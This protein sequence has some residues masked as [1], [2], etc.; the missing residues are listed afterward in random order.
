MMTE[1]ELQQAY[2]NE[3][4]QLGHKE[5][6]AHTLAGR[7]KGLEAEVVSHKLK[8]DDLTRQKEELLK[9]KPAVSEAP[10]VDAEVVSEVKKDA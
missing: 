8:L 3:C 10:I 1:Q 9:K 7:L 5:Y 2:A 6:S 4:A